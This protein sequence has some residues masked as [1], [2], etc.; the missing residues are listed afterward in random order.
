MSKKSFN[1]N[2][3]FFSI[4]QKLAGNLKLQKK[5]LKKILVD[6]G[7]EVVEHC[8]YGWAEVLVAF[9]FLWHDERLFC[10]CR[11]PGSVQVV[12]QRVQLP[13]ITL[14]STVI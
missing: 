8:V 2:K 10:R 6:G 13:H 5:N 11:V 9:H 1:L 3:I 4:F 12:Q 14:T 7:G